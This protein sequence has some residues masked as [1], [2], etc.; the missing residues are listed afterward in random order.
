MPELINVLE[1]APDL[2][3]HLSGPRLEA[4]RRECVAAAVAFRASDLSVIERP[5][6]LRFGV[7]LL[8]L[9]GLLIRSVGLA[10]RFG[11]E[12]LGEGDLLRPWQREDLGTSLPR[13]G[14]W[15]V[16]QPGRAAILDGEFTLRACRYP[17]FISSLVGRAV[18]RSR[19]MTVNMAIMHQPR[20][21]VRLHMLFWELADRFG[22]VRG[23]GIHVPL[24]LTHAMLADLVA[25]RRPT[26]T[27]SL[28]ELAE[29]GVVRW[30]GEDWLLSGEPPA[31]LEAIGRVDVSAEE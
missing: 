18:R 23:D 1:A 29:R 24:R 7:G 15:R 21:D 14:R 4:A 8:I 6:D 16:L 2:A 10:G 9:E 17:E 5:A 27:K 25:A 19:Y 22:R 31:E 3:A 26:V 30:T 12:L 11:A 20:I 13:S 28:G